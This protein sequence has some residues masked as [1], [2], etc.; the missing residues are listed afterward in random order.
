MEHYL[1][2]AVD[3]VTIYKT[4]I[5]ILEFIEKDILI[6]NPPYNGTLPRNKRRSTTASSY[7]K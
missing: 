7:G 5:V 6:K 4:P 1:K 2:E 3:S